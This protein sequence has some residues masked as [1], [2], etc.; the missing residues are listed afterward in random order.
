VDESAC[1]SAVSDDT[2]HHAKDGANVD[3]GVDI[4]AA[5]EWVED[6]AVSSP[7]LLVDDDDLLVLLPSP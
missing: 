3:T 7:T 2:T 1:A 5:I 4:G 6:D